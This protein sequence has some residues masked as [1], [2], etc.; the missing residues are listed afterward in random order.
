MS[1]GSLSR[2]WEVA[3]GEAAACPEDKGGRGQAEQMV[4]AAQ[5]D[6]VAV[7][8]EHAFKLLQ[9]ERL[10]LG[11]GVQCPRRRPARYAHE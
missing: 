7:E 4:G 1:R 8:Y 2:E 10:E 6:A 9:R 3:S 11:K 5:R